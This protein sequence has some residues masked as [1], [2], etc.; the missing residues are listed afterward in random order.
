MGDTLWD[1]RVQATNVSGDLPPGASVYFT[2]AYGHSD[3]LASGGSWC[4]ILGADGR[5]QIPLILQKL[6]NGYLEARSPYGYS[7][8]QIHSDLGQRQIESLWE[9]SKSTLR[10]L[11]VVSLFLRFSP[12]F[13]Y[14]EKFDGLRELSIRTLQPTVSVPTNDRDLAWKAMEGRAR[15]AVRKAERAGMTFG[16]EIP[17]SAKFDLWTDFKNIYT[18]TMQRVNASEKYYFTDEY[19]KSLADLL[20][21][22]LRLATVR[23]A[24]G[25]LLAA[26][27]VLLDQRMAHY[28]LAGST[29]DGARNG[30]NNFMIWGLI[31]WASRQGLAALHLGGGVLP[32]DSLFKFKSSFGGV[33]C[34][35]RVG[36]VVLNSDKYVELTRQAA[37]DQGVSPEQLEASDFFPAFNAKLTSN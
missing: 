12:F 23:S 10:N 4:T 15:T 18:E 19:Y 16:I 24:E 13:S 31:D 35:F 14:A 20:G 5:W 6:P 33:S 30:A 28:H 27:L 11:G 36:E 34:T 26:C 25:Q 21:E 3:A 8:I 37:L 29:R 22:N 32:G 9:N 7:G 17:S 2:S 1:L